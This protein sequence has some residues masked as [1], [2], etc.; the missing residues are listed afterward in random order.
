MKIT[1]DSDYC[2]GCNICIDVCPKNIFELSAQRSKLGYLMPAAK[3]EENCIECLL[4][5]QL[6]P[7]LCINVKTES[8]GS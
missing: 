5:E 7:E 1:V 3:N 8:G 2:K 4:C 6:C